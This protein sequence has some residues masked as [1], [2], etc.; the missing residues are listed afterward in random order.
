LHVVASSHAVTVLARAALDDVA[1]GVSRF[2]VVGGGLRGRSY[3]V[4][5]GRLGMNRG[6]SLLSG[7]LDDPL[8]GWLASP[9]GRALGLLHGSGLEKFSDFISSPTGIGV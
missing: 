6:L 7:G 3:S 5:P 4:L 8:R 1:M 2:T 9:Q